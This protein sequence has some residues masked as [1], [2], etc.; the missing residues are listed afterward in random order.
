MTYRTPDN[1]YFYPGGSTPSQVNQI[2][3]QGLPGVYLAIT[4]NGLMKTVNDGQ[5]WGYLRPNAEF[6][7]TWP[8]GAVGRQVSFMVGARCCNEEDIFA[9]GHGDM[10]AWFLNN[11]QDN[12]LLAKY[13]GDSQWQSLGSISGFLVEPSF[14]TE[15]SGL[16]SDIVAN[17]VDLD[18]DKI[19]VSLDGGISFSTLTSPSGITIYIAVD[20]MGRYW[21][22][23][24]SGELWFSI[25]KGQTWSSSRDP[26]GATAPGPAYIMPHPTKPDV[27]AIAWP[28]SPDYVDLKVAT[29]QDGGLNW[30]VVQLDSAAG[31]TVVLPGIRPYLV[32]TNYSPACEGP[33][34]R[35]S[36]IY[37]KAAGIFPTWNSSIRTSYSEDY[38]ATWSAIEDIRSFSGSV[39]SGPV[40]HSLGVTS[41]G[42]HIWVV[43]D[44]FN[45]GT[46]EGIL[47]R[48]KLGI[49]WEE[50]SSPN[51]GNDGIRSERVIILDDGSL[52][53]AF[54][55]GA[56]LTDVSMRQLMDAADVSAGDEFWN[57]IL[58]PFQGSRWLD[59]FT[60]IASQ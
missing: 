26:T 3:W 8:A 47:F 42:V 40:V 45:D 2:L 15:R 44:Y 29:T 49:D 53:V 37:T 30:E 5:T 20:A 60:R 12:S 17:G 39:G 23:T 7:N 1:Q 56:A 25:D 27:I 19:Y 16:N 14:S 9:F 32:W 52:V 41:N 50:L 33:V 18:T 34:D 13:L 31:E 51:A 6:S 28:V 21:L 46:D 22:T 10:Y 24:T 43:P 59:T 58:L 4:S 48:S 57:T 38:G 11:D 54:D 36:V 35:L 55:I